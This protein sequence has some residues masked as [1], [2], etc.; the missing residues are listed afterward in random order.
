MNDPDNTNVQK[1]EGTGYLADIIKSVMANT[2]PS[3]NTA[4]NQPEKSAASAPQPM[5][6]ILSSLL[7]NPELLSK[8][9][10]LISTAK[11]I[12][13]VLGGLSKADSSALAIPESSNAP[14]VAASKSL[15][16]PNSE[17]EPSRAPHD[18]RTALLCAMKP[19]LS[20]D[21]Q[22]AIDY[23]IKLGRLGDILKTL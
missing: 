16:N 23:I 4:S 21:R 6:D 3:G 9:P 19:Y 7:S 17:Q 2:D 1:S 12:I 8:L 18:R 11:P 22:Q 10:K 13:D 5:P 14:A 20:H 15:S